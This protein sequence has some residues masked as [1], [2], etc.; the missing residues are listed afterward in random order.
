MQSDVQDRN[1]NEGQQQE[2]RSHQGR[3]TINPKRHLT[4]LASTA[5]TDVANSQATRKLSV[6]EQGNETT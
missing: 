2:K 6:E 4:G 3:A 1:T 5:S